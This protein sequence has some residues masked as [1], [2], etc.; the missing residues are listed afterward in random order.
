MS[1]AEDTISRKLLIDIKT[2]QSYGMALD[3]DGNC[4]GFQPL[5][6][7]IEGSEGEVFASDIDTET[8]EEKELILP[9][10]E[11]IYA[12]DLLQPAA[13]P[14]LYTVKF[15]T[16]KEAREKAMPK[17][18]SK[19]MPKDL[20]AAGI[21]AAVGASK[22][23]ET[24]LVKDAAGID[25]AMAKID[26]MIGLD[27]AKRE[28]RRNI[29]RAFFNEAKKEMGLGT[30]TVSRHM[31]FTGNPGTGKTTFAR[32]LA[33]AYKAMGLI[34]GGQLVE[35]SRKDLVSDHVGGTAKA[36]AKAVEKAIG[37]VLFIDEAYQLV[38]GAGSGGKGAN[39]GKEALDTLVAEMENH[40][41]DLI[42]IVAGYTEPMKKLIEMNEGLKSRFNVYLDFKD[43]TRS[44]FSAILD[45]ML[46]DG[47]YAIEAAARQHILDIVEK[48]KLSAGNKFANAREVRNAVDQAEAALSERLFAEGIIGPGAVKREEAEFKQLISTITF[49]DVMAVNLGG[50]DKTATANGQTIAD[51]MLKGI[52]K[53]FTATAVN[54]NEQPPKKDTKKKRTA[55]KA[56]P[57]K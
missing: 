51:S 23:G 40:R 38:E 33:Q 32:E 49:A 22:A 31:V 29:A 50:I 24:Q 1:A 48:Q 41:D 15:P 53:E 34:T 27:D 2:G 19:P 42:V 43:Y 55:N 47:G 25:E 3:K 12:V 16:A 54:S 8:G 46:E 6:T 57:A 26:R 39:W 30:R 13:K 14:V 4:V 28:V 45:T 17:V 18:S 5:V 20:V 44:Q 9:F 56:N 10:G 36:V 7:I 35:V 11:T 37:G 52:K 21:A